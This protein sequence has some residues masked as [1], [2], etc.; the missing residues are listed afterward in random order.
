MRFCTCSGRHVSAHPSLRTPIAVRCHPWPLLWITL[1]TRLGC[2]CIQHRSV[3]GLYCLM[4]RSCATRART[5][6]SR[7]SSSLPGLEARRTLPRT[8][9][10]AD[11][12]A[13]SRPG[14]LRLAH[15]CGAGCAHTA[16]LPA[17][18]P[19][20]TNGEPEELS[21]TSVS[22]RRKEPPIFI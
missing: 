19:E 3:Q 22:R 9:E 4:Q 1:L 12:P 15:P 18:G 13:G 2:R 5:L 16:A 17:V 21:N 10:Y 6:I 14:T 8:S 7:R 20:G 11:R